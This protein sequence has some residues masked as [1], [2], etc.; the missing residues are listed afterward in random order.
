M[1]LGKRSSAEG[2]EDDEF[3]LGFLAY[4]EHPEL[5]RRSVR[6]P[7]YASRGDPEIQTP[8]GPSRWEG[9][10]ACATDL[11]LRGDSAP[12]SLARRDCA[13]GVACNAGIPKVGHARGEVK[14]VHR[15]ALRTPWDAS[16]A[17]LENRLHDAFGARR[18]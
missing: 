14:T 5:H 3:I 18:H 4:R 6:R 15:R 10:A 13:I 17:R 12:G 9:R 7:V 1:P 16:S 2:V 11:E 8:P